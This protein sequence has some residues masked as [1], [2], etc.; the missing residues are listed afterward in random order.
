V[1]YARPQINYGIGGE[2][3]D[4]T[5]ADAGEP[6]AIRWFGSSYLELPLNTAP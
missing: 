3:S 1:T 2:V 4:E 5:I 6:V